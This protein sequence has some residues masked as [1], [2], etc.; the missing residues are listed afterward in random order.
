MT[1]KR[2]DDQVLRFRKRIIY[3]FGS[4]GLL[5][6]SF[7]LIVG[8]LTPDTDS[9]NKLV[10]LVVAVGG[11]FLWPPLLVLGRFNKI[12]QAGVLFCFIGALLVSVSQYYLST[13]LFIPILYVLVII[14]AS[15]L[16]RPVATAFYGLMLVLL[17][18][19]INIWLIS[20]LPTSTPEAVIS[21]RWINSFILFAVLLASTG[22]LYSFS[23]TLGRVSGSF[24]R[25]AD[26]LARLNA[27][28]QRQREV[29]SQI[30][31]QIRDLTGTLSQVF[32]VQNSTG[33]R[34]AVIISDVAATTQELDAAARRIADN[35]L[36]VA[37]VAEKAQRSVEVGQEAAYQGVNAIAAMRERVQDISHNMR[38]LTFQLERS[39]RSSVSSGRL[40]TR[41]I[42]WLLT[43]R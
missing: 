38:T 26:E 21:T 35:A 11:L 41:L 16:I 20:H 12:R 9:N 6:V 4:I 30:A 43:L 37:T 27:T 13:D 29:E 25:Q 8:I 3:I 34:Q 24:R 23:D 36:S 14:M 7:N 15:T 22:L 39:T 42:C 31:A 19:G 1:I 33:Q 17:S 2:Q 32:T 40:P 28:L 10:R 18:G 5:S